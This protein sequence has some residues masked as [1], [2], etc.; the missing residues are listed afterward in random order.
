MHYHD[1][2]MQLATI[3]QGDL[4]RDASFARSARSARTARLAA[5]RDR[6]RRA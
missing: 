2:A 5:R 6:R 3:R 1:T 4:L